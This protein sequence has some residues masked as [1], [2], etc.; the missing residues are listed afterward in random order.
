MKKLMIIALAGISVL[1]SCKKEKSTSMVVNVPNISMEILGPQ[2]VSTTVGS[3]FVDNYGANF[4]NEN[5]GVD[6]ISSPTSSNLDLSTPGFYSI[7]YSAKTK[8]GFKAQ[9]SRLVLVTSVSPAIDYS[10]TYMRLSNTQTITVTKQGTGL[11]KT[12]NIGGVAGD[13]NFIFDAYFGQIDD[14]TIVIP[15]QYNDIVGN[16]KGVGNV[17]ITSADTT[18][19]WTI[20]GDSYGTALRQFKKVP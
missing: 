6:F 13:P 1:I 8:Y 3:S 14:S 9:A 4:H 16:Y 15:A 20:D 5:G 18:L 17:V 11:Y 10:G 12:D 2:V 19:Q 7:T